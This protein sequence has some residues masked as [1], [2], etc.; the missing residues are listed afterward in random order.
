MSFNGES[1]KLLESGR[2]SILNGRRSFLLR[3]PCWDGFGGKANRKA[4]SLR[5]TKQNKNRE[6]QPESQVP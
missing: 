4:R 6:T 2:T 5:T 1:M 3:V